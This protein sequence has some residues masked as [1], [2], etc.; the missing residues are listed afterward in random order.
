MSIS[1][2]AFS[3]IRGRGSSGPA[4]GLA[5]GEHTAFSNSGLV[6]GLAH[7]RGTVKAL[8][9]LG[10]LEGRESRHHGGL[11]AMLAVSGFM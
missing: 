3:S 5:A 1:V 10:A 11:E 9:V 2:Q 6:T 8:M 7:S 4:P